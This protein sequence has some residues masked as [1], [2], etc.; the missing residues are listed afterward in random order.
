MRNSIPTVSFNADPRRLNPCTL[1]LSVLGASMV[2]PLTGIDAMSFQIVA[3]D[4]GGWPSGAVLTFEI[5]NDGFTFD[6]VPSGAVTYGS[7]GTKEVMNVQGIGWGRLRVS[8]AAASAYRV[9]I[10]ATGAGS[11]A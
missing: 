9:T 1:D 10:A 7:A 5:G 2:V 6:P 11:G 8:T 4:L 3:L